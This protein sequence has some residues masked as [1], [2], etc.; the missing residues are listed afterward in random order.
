[1]TPDDTTYRQAGGQWWIPIPNQV[2]GAPPP[3]GSPNWLVNCGGGNVFRIG[4]YYP[5]NETFVWDGQT[6]ELEH[7]QTG[8]VFIKKKNKESLLIL[9]HMHIYIVYCYFKACTRLHLPKYQ[10]LPN[11][12]FFYSFDIAFRRQHGPQ[13]VGCAGWCGQQQ[14]HDDDW[15]GGGL[16]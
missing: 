14:P 13:V 5:E 16:L 10:L 6:T 4:N 11:T 2:G 9:L 15:V 1:M 12:D 3:E 7:G 8:Q